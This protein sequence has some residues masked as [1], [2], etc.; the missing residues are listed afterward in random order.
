MTPKIEESFS[1][2]LHLISALNQTLVSVRETELKPLGIT[3]QQSA[4]LHRVYNLGDNA[5]VSNIAKGVQR[6]LSSVLTMLSRLESRGLVKRFINPNDRR[7]VYAFLTEK[8][9][10]IHAHV[11]NKPDAFDLVVTDMTMPNISGDMLAREATKI[12]PDIPV[13]LCTGFSESIT[14]ETA[15]GMGIRKFAFKPLVMKD[16]A[17]IIRKVLDE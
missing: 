10:K 5:T 16:L 3:A 6:D 7:Q 13:I 9:R 15:E 8:G 11:R 4:I 17:M 2:T 1:D 14:E 12:R